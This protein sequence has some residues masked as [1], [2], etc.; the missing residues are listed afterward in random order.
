MLTIYCTEWEHSGDAD[1]YLTV[2]AKLGT[3]V[4]TVHDLESEEGYFV[5]ACPPERTKAEAQ[6]ALDADDDTHGFCF[7]Q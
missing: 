1:R 4:R 5:V 7:V 3:V 6:R 2:I